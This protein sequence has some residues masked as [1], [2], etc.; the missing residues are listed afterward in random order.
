VSRQ[1]THRTKSGERGQ[2]I[3]LVLVLL[4]PLLAI[5]GLVID[6]GYAYYAQRS[7]QRQADAAALAGASQLPDPN[8]SLTMARR[9]GSGSGG[10]NRQS[11][12][13]PVTENVTTKCLSSVPSCSPVN[14]VV[15]DET[16]DV[17]TLFSRL[18]GYNSFKVHV[19]ATACSPCGV[20]PLD[21]VVVLDRT[22][23]MCEDHYGNP[24]PSCTD[25][26][27]ARNGIKSF[28]GAMNSDDWVGL[29]VFPPPANLASKCAAPQTS[30]YNSK[31]SPYTV[32]PLSKDFISGGKLVNSSNLVSTINCQQ[33]GGQ[34]SYAN[35]LEAAQAELDKDGRPNVQDV[36]VF[37]SDGAANTGPT[38]YPTTSPYRKQPCHQGVTS[39]GFAKAKGTLVYSIGYDLNAVNGGANRCS[40]YSS[41]G[42]DEQPPITAYQALQSI[43]S[44]SGTFYNQ[45]GPGQLVTLFQQVAQDIQ[46]GAAGLIDNATP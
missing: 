23:S 25:L 36:I 1:P 26:N 28:L 44:N 6:V 27:N 41:S 5:V 19:R 40:A 43:A 42:P 29:T 45:P 16:A 39:A 32:V 31:S 9:Y 37:F 8:L 10:K 2:A 11:N 24:D 33:A 12:L 34:T 13:P 35:A 17:P 46:R 15:V 38:Y 14:A 4:V 7:L 22:G 30:N 18:V 21:I 3:V 20:K